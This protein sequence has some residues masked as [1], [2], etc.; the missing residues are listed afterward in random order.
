VGRGAS[1]TS[2]PVP[3]VA[4]S[5]PSAVAKPTAEPVQ[6]LAVAPDS[7]GPALFIVKG[8]GVWAFDGSK[9]ALVPSLDRPV[10]VARAKLIQIPGGR[11]F[12]SDGLQHQEVSAELRLVP[13]AAG[14]GKLAA[15]GDGALWQ[16]IAEGSQAFVRR[17]DGALD[18]PRQP[19]VGVNVDVMS[20][21]AASAS[22]DLYV[23]TRSEVWVGKGGTWSKIE[24][25]K[26]FDSPEN[27]EGLAPYGSSVAAFGRKQLSLLD[28]K[29]T[30]L[31]DDSAMPINPRVSVGSTW[32]SAFCT[33]RTIVT[34][35]KDGK[36]RR[37][38]VDSLGAKGAE[39]CHS[40]AVDAE[41]RTWVGSNGGLVIFS[42]EGKKLQVWPPG[43]LPGHIDHILVLGRGPAL[44]KDLPPIIKGDAQGRAL[45]NGKPLVESEVMLCDQPDYLVSG[46]TPCTGKAVVVSAKTDAQGAFTLKDV[47]AGNYGFA[48]KVEN[49]WAVIAAQSQCCNQVSA[50]VVTN[51][52]DLRVSVR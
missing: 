32:G 49:E 44:P 14:V 45:V 20:E 10:S 38:D 33:R 35:G 1:E 52:G 50:G 4:T 46:A 24:Q 31:P 15:G 18:T 6:P 48:M 47:P 7:P 34:L 36:V 5:S 51:I 29:K 43:T 27:V 39:L 28:G 16:L 3:V 11:V 26:L 8:S 19:A 42:P 23:A 25:G 30:A 21:F 2:L 40:A 41:G 12:V 13:F 9:L 37:R 22:N 17:V